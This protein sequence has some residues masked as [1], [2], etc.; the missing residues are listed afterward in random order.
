M[1]RLK[2]VYIFTGGTL[3]DEMLSYNNL[4]EGI[5]IGV[6]RGVDWLINHGITPDYFVGDF[7][8]IDIVL[9]ERIKKY[10]SNK[11]K[12]YPSEKDETDTELAM[13]LAI[14]LK[15]QNIIIF[16]GTGS[17][18]DHVI[19]NVHILLQAERNDISS[20]IY[21]T[22]NRIRVLLSGKSKKIMKSH[23][24]YVSIFPFTEVVAGVTLEGFKYPLVKGVMKI[25]FPYGVSNE[26]VEDNG[27]ISLDTGILLIIESKD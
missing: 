12:I 7:D 15:P 6:D 13:Q 26:I 25:G 5:I 4:D 16:G 20:V 27:T 24:S 3:T 21:G 19:A 23:F 11:V 2:N 18:L 14:S 17:R 8:S 10:Y 1:T 22:N 9:L